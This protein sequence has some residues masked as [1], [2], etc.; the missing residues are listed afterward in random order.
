MAKGENI[1]G[2]LGLTALGLGGSAPA[3]NAQRGGGLTAA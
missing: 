3:K 2:K 1:G